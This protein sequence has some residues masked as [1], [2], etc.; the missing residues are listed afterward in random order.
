MLSIATS[1]ALGQSCSGNWTE[2]NGKCSQRFGEAEA[3]R[4]SW[5]A[6][7]DNCV[8]LGGHLASAASVA[9]LQALAAFCYSGVS[10]NHQA[11]CAVGLYRTEDT[12]RET[13]VN[14]WAWTDGSPWTAEMDAE[15]LVEC[16]S[17]TA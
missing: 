17:D 13:K 12:G 2:L 9:E 11:D 15:D 16:W 3:Y 8:S 1:A 7:Q 4:I 10:T 5:Q 6:A 14:N